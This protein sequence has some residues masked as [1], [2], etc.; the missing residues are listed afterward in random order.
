MWKIILI[1]LSIS[2]GTIF[3]AR[4][5]SSRY[6]FQLGEVILYVLF[7]L[8]IIK[9]YNNGFKIRLS[10]FEKIFLILQ[11]FCGMYA[12]IIFLWSDFG[13]SVLPG[14]LSIL[15]GFITFILA[16]VWLRE[17]IKGYEIANRIFLVSIVFQLIVNMGLNLNSIGGQYIAFKIASVTLMGQSNYISIF[18]GFF[19]LY[20]FI[21]RKKY[22]LFFVIISLIGVFLTL[23]RGAILSIAFSI[24]VYI[25]IILYNSQVNKLKSIISILFVIS[26]AYY[27]FSNTIIGIELFTQ[28]N[29]G[30]ETG[31]SSG[32]DVLIENAIKQIVNQP[33]GSGIV[34]DNDPHNVIFKTLRDLGILVGPIYI[35]LLLYPVYHLFNLRSYKYSNTTIGLLIGYLSVILHSMVE[36]FYFNSSSIIWTIFTLVAINIMM[37]AEKQKNL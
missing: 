28:I 15:I 26:A 9:T 11:L 5:G 1:F 36:I 32:R 18:L 8:F 10:L 4:F 14:A 25:I 21:S 16:K 34:L 35:T 22:W 31:N 37:H 29:Y 2:F 3:S 6:N 27:L 17:N 19:F 7:F 20:E 23:S 24:I 30:F 12:I 13:L 33:F